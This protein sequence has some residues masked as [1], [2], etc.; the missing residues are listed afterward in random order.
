MIIPHNRLLYI[1]ITALFVFM[2]MT[3]LAIATEALASDLGY[4]LYVGNEIVSSTNCSGLGWSYDQSTRTLTL[5]NYVFE[6][7]GEGYACIVPTGR[8]LQHGR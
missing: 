1:A 4:D 8:N 7:A 3:G 2:M 5:N 6:G